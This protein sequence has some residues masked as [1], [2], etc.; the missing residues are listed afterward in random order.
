MGKDYLKKIKMNSLLTVHRSKEEADDSQEDA[1]TDTSI[2]R[3]LSNNHTY[4]VFNIRQ[5]KEL[6]HQMAKAFAIM[7]QE[8]IVLDLSSSF[9]VA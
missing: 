5:L 4:S 9:V 3:G 8:T 2:V 7:L 1:Q 6:T